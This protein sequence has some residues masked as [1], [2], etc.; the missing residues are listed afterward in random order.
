MEFAIENAQTLKKRGMRGAFQKQ[1][2]AAEG[3]AKEGG[4]DAMGAAVA[5]PRQRKSRSGGRARAPPVAAAAGAA[6]SPPA[7][8]GAEA[9][10]SRKQQG[11]RK[12]A[13][14][15]ASRQVL[16]LVHHCIQPSAEVH[17]TPACRGSSPFY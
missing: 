6:A 15:A 14:R 11:K 17:G 12:R 8:S 10:A 1:R 5:A 16:C 4:P 2:P 13:E 9:P 7:P 3:A